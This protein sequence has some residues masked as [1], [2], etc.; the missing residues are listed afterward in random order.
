M[1]KHTTIIIFIS[2]LKTKSIFLNVKVYLNVDLRSI[3]Y[4]KFINYNKI[5]TLINLLEKKIQTL[6]KTL[7]YLKNKTSVK[8]AK[9]NKE[10]C[11]CFLSKDDY[12][13]T[14]NTIVEDKTK[15]KLV[16]QDNKKNQIPLI[17][18]FEHIRDI[19]K[20]NLKQH[21]DNIRY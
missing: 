4:I 19:I 20:Q 21:I 1:I 5:K 15:F 9:C 10:N 18:R 11:I 3:I 14:L 17:K 8:I 6:N 13:N 12:L 2:L 16:E 7:F